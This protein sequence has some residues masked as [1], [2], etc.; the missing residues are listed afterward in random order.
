MALKVNKIKW[1]CYKG[2]VNLSISLRLQNFG[3][4]LQSGLYVNYTVL[5]KL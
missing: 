4:T 3:M 5:L 2:L 1:T